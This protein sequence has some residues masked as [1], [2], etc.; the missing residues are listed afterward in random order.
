[1]SNV[2]PTFKPGG[3]VKSGLLSNYCEA[4]HSHQT[5]PSEWAE[6]II[7]LD[8]NKKSAELYSERVKLA[9]SWDTIT[10]NFIKEIED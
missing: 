8:Y 6:A 5:D 2:P 7:N 3:K 1:M 9:H 10:Q 4:V